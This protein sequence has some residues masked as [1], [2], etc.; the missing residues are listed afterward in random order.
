MLRTA[1]ASDEEV[2]IAGASKNGQYIAVEVSDNGPGI[3][4]DIRPRIFNLGF[5]TRS[6]GTGLGLSL[7]KRD[8]ERHK[9]KIVE[10]GKTGADFLI[11]LPASGRV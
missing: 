7:V 3:P 2:K 6:M 8:V 9:G 4:D 11:I 5:S 10:V 1:L